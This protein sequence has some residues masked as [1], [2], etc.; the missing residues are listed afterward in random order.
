MTVQVLRGFL[1]SMI[2]SKLLWEHQSTGP[3]IGGSGGEEITEEPW[4]RIAGRLS[5]YGDIGANAVDLRSL[6]HHLHL[7]VP[8]EM[9]APLW[10]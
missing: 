7:V 8:L 3:S 9:A 1:L 2:A 6:P 5:N 4:Y 10:G